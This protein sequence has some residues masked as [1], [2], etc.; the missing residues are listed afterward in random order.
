MFDFEVVKKTKLKQKGELER[1]FGVSRPMVNRY[2]TGKS[3]PRGKNRAHTRTAL[4][5]LS[6]LLEA[7]KLPLS[8]DKDSA[9]RAAAVEKI[10]S[11]V[12]QIRN[13]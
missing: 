11:H 1:L 7:G 3:L 8:E 13:K 9:A 12:V 6:K 2:M 5:V 10:Y 4:N